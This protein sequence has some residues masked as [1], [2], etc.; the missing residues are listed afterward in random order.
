MKII[1]NG[2]QCFLVAFDLFF[3]FVLFGRFSFCL[4]KLWTNRSVLGRF[5]IQNL[6]KFLGILS[7]YMKVSTKWPKLTSKFV[8]YPW[9]ENLRHA[10]PSQ[11]RNKATEGDTVKGTDN[12]QK[13]TLFSNKAMLYTTHKFMQSSLLAWICA[14]NA[15]EL[16]T[17]CAKSILRCRKKRLREIDT[18]MQKALP[19]RYYLH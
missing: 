4:N 14:W 18:A 1:F 3:T 8:V 6:N 7:K 16:D 19:A 5:W 13:N 15:C 2:F 12:I 11:S 10:Q 17:A 9:G